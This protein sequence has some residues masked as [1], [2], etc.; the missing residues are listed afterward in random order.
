MIN[1]L[2]AIVCR[3]VHEV[4][5]LAFN[6]EQE[7]AVI[8]RDKQA[9]NMKDSFLKDDIATGRTGDMLS[10]LMALEKVGASRLF[11]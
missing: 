7:N 4:H 8:N 1:P 10:T 11:G 3:I 6:R 2:P 5:S 9:A